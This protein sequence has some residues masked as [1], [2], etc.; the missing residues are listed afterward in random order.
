MFPFLST[1][2]IQ[3]INRINNIIIIVRQPLQKNHIQGYIMNIIYA[4]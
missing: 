3:Y 1:V 2:H 4:L